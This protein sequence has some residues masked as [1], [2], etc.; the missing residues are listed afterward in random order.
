MINK[1]TPRGR[2]PLRKFPKG[3]DPKSTKMTELY[4]KDYFRANS[5]SYCPSVYQLGSTVF[6]A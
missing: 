3:Y 4:V 5:L 6:I 1:G 2:K